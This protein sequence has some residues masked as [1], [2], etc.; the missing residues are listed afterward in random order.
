MV[1]W[2]FFVCCV[3]RF[4]FFSVV[5]ISA[6]LNILT[7]QL[8]GHVLRLLLV[9][10]CYMSP[11]RVVAGE[12]STTVGTWH[13]DTLMSLADVGAEVRFVAVLAITEG[14]L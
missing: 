2:Q 10:P 12:G 8:V 5:F 13:A 11:D 14:T 4:S 9:F 3:V 6:Q 7:V 1:C